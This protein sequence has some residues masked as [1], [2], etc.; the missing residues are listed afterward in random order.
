MKYTSIEHQT[1]QPTNQ[2]ANH[3]V[4]H[5]SCYSWDECSFSKSQHKSTK[6]FFLSKSSGRWTNSTPTTTK[7]KFYGFKII[8]YIFLLLLLQTLIKIC[9]KYQF[10]VFY[11]LCFLF[12][13]F[14]LIW[15]LNQVKG[16]IL[17]F[18]D[19]SL[20]SIYFGL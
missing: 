19:R 5:S 10:V 20:K 12:F 9:N 16:I 13:D 6:E 2:R 3:T 15:K 17:L 8:S 18:G 7:I 4:K 14:D 11:F 1:F